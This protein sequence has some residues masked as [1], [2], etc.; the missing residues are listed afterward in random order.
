ME[1]EIMFVF[2]LNDLIMKIAENHLYMVMQWEN[3]GTYWDKW[4]GKTI[5]HWE[6]MGD[7]WDIMGYN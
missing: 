5:G 1:F 6:C 7:S 2:G 3:D 4:G